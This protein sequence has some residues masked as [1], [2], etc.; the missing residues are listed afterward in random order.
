MRWVLITS[1]ALL[2]ACASTPGD[3]DTRTK[4]TPTAESTKAGDLS[5]RQMG[6]GECGLF[7]WTADEA[8]NFILFS[9]AGRFRGAWASD[10]GEE[11]LRI[12]DQD[13]NSSQRQYTDTVFQTSNGD[14]LSLS[15]RR[16]QSITGGTRYKAGTLT[17]TSDA[18]W[19]KV[20]PVVGLSA[21]R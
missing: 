19:D 17:Q 1:F 20:I 4:T 5:A 14:K 2:S 3:T 11:S 15:L 21:C 18:G 13:G 6:V 8:R 10:K 16:S 9:Q 12:I 7:V